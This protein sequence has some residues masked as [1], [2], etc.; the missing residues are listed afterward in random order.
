MI[1]RLL[2]WFGDPA[3]WQGLDGIP[4]RLLEH[5]GYSLVALVVALVIA[6]PVGLWIGHTGRGGVVVAG[7]ANGFRALPTFG[8][9]IAAVIVLSGVFRGKTDLGYVLPTLLV[10]V[11]LGV[12]PILAGTYAGVHGVDRAARDAAYG[13][14]M[15]G[16]QVLLRV[17]APCALPLIMSGVRSAML[18][19]VSTATFAAYVSL[20]GLGRFIF[21]G[22]ASNRFEVMLGGSLLVAA[23]A[24]VAELALAALQRVIVSP[25][26][27]HRR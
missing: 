9:L 6:V 19:I 10:L 21:D 3:N 1:S 22:Q 14:G 4:N 16:R 23:L 11:I 5:I 24:I 18:Q 2:A 8:L 12:P 13:M 15:T 7:L 25:G 17:E 20:G 27:I 26:L